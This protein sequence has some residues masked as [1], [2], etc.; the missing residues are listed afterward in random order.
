MSENSEFFFRHCVVSFQLC[1]EF[2][3]EFVL[4]EWKVGD[5][6]KV[7][8][9]RSSLAGNEDR[10][11]WK[12]TGLEVIAANDLPKLKTAKIFVPMSLMRQHSSGRRIDNIHNWG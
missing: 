10:E 6:D 12:E 9:L 11:L 5:V 7:Q 4:V 2:I 3:L 8:R 1:I